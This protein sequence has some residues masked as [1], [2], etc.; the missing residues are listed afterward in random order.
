MTYK[1]GRPP[2]DEDDDSTSVHVTIPSRQY[3]EL[4]SRASRERISVPEISRRAVSD[5]KT[6][7][8]NGS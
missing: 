2:L 1:L 3:D 8:D 7:K 6:E 5:R 4:C